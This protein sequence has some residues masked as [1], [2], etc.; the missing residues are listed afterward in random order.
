MV[1]GDKQCKEVHINVFISECSF[2]VLERSRLP[3]KS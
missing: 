1:L 2:D 3:H